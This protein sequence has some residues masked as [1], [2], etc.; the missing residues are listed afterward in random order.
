MKEGDFV[1]PNLQLV[2]P[3]G[4]GGMGAV[5]IG[6]NVSLDAEVAVKFI[7][8]E[9]T[10]NAAIRERFQREAAMA[11]KVKSPHIVQIYDHGVS[12]EGL[13][14][15]VMELL[16]GEELSG[17]LERE[18][19]LPLEVV[20]TVLHQAAKG[21]ARAHQ[22]GIVHRDIKPSNI[23]LVD[24]D[25]GE[26]FVKVLDFG[27]A[28]AENNTVPS[29]MTATGAMLGTPFY[30]SPEQVLSS[31]DA[32]LRT[33]L[34]S[35]AVVAYECLTGKLPFEGETLG[36]LW[37]AI[38]N[39]ELV[40]PSKLV[41]S[42]P[43]LVDIWFVRALAKAR[44]ERYQSTR[45]LAEAFRAA[46]PAASE[47]PREEPTAQFPVVSVPPE[48]DR[49]A[50]LEATVGLAQVPKAPRVPDDMGASGPPA[51]TSFVAEPAR[52]AR[53]RT[54]AISLVV[55]A[56]VLGC[57]AAVGISLGTRKSAAAPT[58]PTPSASQPVGMAIPA[59]EELRP[60]VATAAP[61]V[62]AT[63]SATALAGGSARHPHVSGRGQPVS[64]APLAT[65]RSTGGK[66][67]GF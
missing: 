41:P 36:G 5:W 46:I 15:I 12:A 53:P 51:A 54:W 20:A 55:A 2:R 57:I 31:K 28:K 50:D 44:Q 63:A 1:T 30:M 52:P 18:G 25:D 23:F 48:Q 27:I 64:T 62:S 7:T 58:P 56:F 60:A 42:I 67:R 4:A 45:E 13:P 49:N 14:Y 32:D 16:H 33:D 9:A 24:N 39:A 19:T 47:V 65:A 8:G 40:P 38:N 10:Q 6:K 61:S 21:L 22:A 29:S 43:P 11:A 35:L 66:D 26:I 59:P 34:W 17:R 37:I 3:L